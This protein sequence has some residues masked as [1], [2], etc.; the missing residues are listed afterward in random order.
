MSQR[1]TVHAV[2]LLVLCAVLA[3]IA[4]TCLRGTRVSAQGGGAPSQNAPVEQTHP[5]IKVL[6][7]LPESQLIPVMYN[8]SASLGVRCDFCHARTRD[9]KTGVEHVDFASDAKEEKET[10]RHMMQMTMGINQANKADVGSDPVSC[11]TC[12]RGSNHPANATMLPITLPTPPPGAPGAGGPGGQG[13][14]P[15]GPPPQG[16]QA[17]PA[18]APQ[19]GQ[20]PPP[21]S[22]PQGAPGVAPRPQPPP[23]PSAQALID[24]YVTAVGGREAVAKVQTRNLKGTRLGAQGRTFPIDVSIKGTDK[25]MT[26]ATTPQGMVNQGYN[27]TTGWLVNP[28]GRGAANAEELET[29]KHAAEIYN[30]LQLT[31]S[32]PTM[33]VTRPERVGE[34][35]ANVITNVSAP[36]VVEKF[37]F[38]AETGLLL[39]RQRFT[40]TMIGPIPEQWDFQDYRDVNG[41]KVPYTIV[42][43]TPNPNDSS[44][45][46]FTEIKFN[47]PV[48]DT[49]FQMPAAAPQPAATPRP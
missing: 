32:A 18:G 6:K 47:M 30:L 5:N 21:G 9:P 24:K 12:H 39:R 42:S 43:S 20:T 45:R 37:Y 15:A 46:T 38:D 10:A 28:Q 22:G 4:I 17:P 27:G 19:G 16:G 36:G 11:Y 40:Q 26:V 1:R 2:K 14:P 33:R 31:A 29:L 3:L 25:F 13:T 44:T 48:D 41:V 7:G 23:R 35:Q 49:Q 8:I 34:R